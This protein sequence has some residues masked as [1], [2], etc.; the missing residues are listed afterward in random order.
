MSDAYISVLSEAAANIEILCSPSGVF[1]L[2][3]DSTSLISDI[4]K[5][6]SSWS[7]KEKSS[8]NSEVFPWI[9][10]ISHAHVRLEYSQLLR[11]DF[12]KFPHLG[13]LEESLVFFSSKKALISKERQR[14]S[15]AN[16]LMGIL[17]AIDKKRV[18]LRHEMAYRYLRLFLLTYVYG[19]Y[20][21]GGILAL[22]MLGQLRL[23]V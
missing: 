17:Q 15:Q 1:N 11:L 22:F 21:E 13:E 2:D 19:N 16:N 5:E 7:E 4:M 18:D 3:D 6:T 23:S 8:V 10:V 20:E 9:S 14:S 12:K